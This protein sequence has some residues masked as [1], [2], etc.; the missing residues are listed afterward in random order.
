MSILEIIQT[1]SGRRCILPDASAKFDESLEHL[2]GIS[3]AK[4][5]VM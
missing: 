1:Y 3:Y 5:T 4:Y 2:R